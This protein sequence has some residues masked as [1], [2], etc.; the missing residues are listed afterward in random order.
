MKTLS[1]FHK[2]N[3]VVAEGVRSLN[4]IHPKSEISYL[5]YRGW[6]KGSQKI[7]PVYKVILF[8]KGIKA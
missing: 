2:S 7:S 5:T 6:I 8:L 1:Q 4:S 3:P